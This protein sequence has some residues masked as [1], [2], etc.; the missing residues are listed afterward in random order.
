MT[1]DFYILVDFREASISYARTRISEIFS[2]NTDAKIRDVEIVRRDCFKETLSNVIKAAC[3]NG[4]VVISIRTLTESIVENLKAVLS[5]SPPANCIL[6]S[7]D[8]EPTEVSDIK[9]VEYEKNNLQERKEDNPRHLTQY[10]MQRHL[11]YPELELKEFVANLLHHDLA[12][13]PTVDDEKNDSTDLAQIAEISSRLLDENKGNGETKCKLLTT[14]NTTI[15][16]LQKFEK[17]PE[18]KAAAKSTKHETSLEQFINLHDLGMAG[19]TYPKAGEEGNTNQLINNVRET[20]LLNSFSDANILII[21]ESGTGKEYAAWATHDLSERKGKPFIAINCA[22]IPDTLLESELFGYL[23]GSHHG[24][25]TD[26]EGLVESADGG[27]LFLDELPE[28]STLL[29]AKLL[30]FAQ[31]GEY[32]PIGATENTE[33]KVRIIA[34]GQ[35]KLLFDAKRVR[36]DLLY[37]LNQLELKL[38]P[39]RDL[40]VIKIAKILLEGM[41]WGTRPKITYNK[42]TGHKKISRETLTPKLVSELQQTLQKSLT[43]TGLLQ[44]HQWHDSN[45]RQ[46]YSYLYRWVI[47][48][49]D[50]Y[51]KKTLQT[52]DSSTP[53]PPPR[54]APTG[55][56]QTSN[57]DKIKEQLF[58]LFKGCALKDAPPLREVGCIMMDALNEHPGKPSL[59]TISTRLGWTDKTMRKW[60]EGIKLRKNVPQEKE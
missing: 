47:Y 51:L 42:K 7:H 6:C 35:P 26:K 12:P 49:N 41:T 50:D 4:T 10:L 30:R 23:K 13:A 32:R 59:K 3:P 29:Q 44:D 60:R 25:E 52:V 56:H 8:D 2:K 37:R 34:A 38:P 55:S 58:E 18:K 5:T 1:T 33:V 11:I 21:G 31:T 16:E 17:S 15:E 43:F 57:N 54:T 27:T 9:S 19:G 48:S 46:L 53:K 28:M 40:N 22:A 24:A 39:L 36:P 14:L 45:V 20:I